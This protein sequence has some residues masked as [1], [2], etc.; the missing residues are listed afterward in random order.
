M[1]PEY[2]FYKFLNTLW[3]CHRVYALPAHRVN[4]LWCGKVFT[5]IS[6]EYPSACWRDEI[7]LVRNLV[8]V[9]PFP[10]MPHSLLWGYLLHQNKSLADRTLFLIGAF[11]NCG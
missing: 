6:A 2:D 11:A 4:A 3:S 5:K 8:G 9:A 10:L 1:K 7:G